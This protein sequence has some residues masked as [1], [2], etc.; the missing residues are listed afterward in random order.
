[1]RTALCAPDDIPSLAFGPWLAT[2]WA[3]GLAVALLLRLAPASRR[4]PGA[5][6]RALGI[7]LLTVP[8]WQA[9]LSA[10]P[11][12]VRT[13][14]TNGNVQAI[15]PGPPQAAYSPTFLSAWFADDL[16]RNVGTP[17]V[18]ALL[19]AQGA[20]P[21]FWRRPTLR[22]IGRGLAGLAP[23]GPQGDG[24]ALRR[25]A[26]L[27]PLL[28][29]A[30]VA[31]LALAGAPFRSQGGVSV[32]ANATAYHAALLA[33]AAGVGEEVVFRGV[34][35]QGLKRLLARA[36]LPGMGATVAALWVQAVP[37]AYLHAYYGDLSA[38]GLALGFGL[39]AG[40]ATEL[41]GLGAAMA[42][43]ALVDFAAFALAMPSW[44][45]GMLAAIA[46][47]SLAVAACVALELRAAI[48]RA[49]DAPP[50]GL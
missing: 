28:A 7:G 48:A 27:F 35:Q 6:W 33:L 2:S 45:P 44:G 41:W 19:L 3:L 32:Y 42:L 21:T 34:L 43:H 30:N 20:D 47:A 14:C 12:M 17:L 24:I 29:L 26:A 38:L 23:M 25:G 11:D 1:M 37:F 50:D 5:T 9:V 36:G 18:G 8:M 22:G 49:K 10:L 40:A 13:V 46:L 16:L 39:V 31:L 15:L 4:R